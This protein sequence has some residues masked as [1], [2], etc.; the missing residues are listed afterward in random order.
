MFKEFRMK[1]NKL[2]ALRSIAIIALVAIIGF[3]FVACD[4]GGGGT[5]PTI[6]TTT[7]AGGTV[8]T[9]YSRTLTATGDTPITWTLDSGNLPTSLTISTAGVI[10]GTPTVANTFNF[11]VKAT[12]ATDSVT[13]DLSIV[14]A[15]AG[16]PVINTETLPNGTVGTPYS[17]TLTATGDTPITWSIETGELPDGLS[18]GQTTGVISGTPTVADTFDFTVKATNAIGSG[19]EPFTIVI[20]SSGHVHTFQLELK[21]TH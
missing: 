16:S 12:N 1:T 14:I 6:T 18:I 13:K 8:G 5:A 9:P 7:L 15:P 4:N 19:T 11:K 3:S 17:Q 10:S 21:R 2:N 20:A